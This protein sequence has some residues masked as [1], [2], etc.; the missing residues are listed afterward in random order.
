MQINQLSDNKYLTYSTFLICVA[1]SIILK[2]NVLEVG[3]PFVTIDD[4]STYEGGFLVWFGHPQPQRMYL[5]SWLN[6]F[7]SILTYVFHQLYHGGSLGVNLVVDAYNHYVSDPDLYVKSYRFFIII[8]DLITAFFVLLLSKR[9]LP[10]NIKYEN[11]PYLISA[12]YLLSFNTIW[13]FVVARPDT[14]VATFGVIGMY[15]YYRSSFGSNIRSFYLSA[16]FFGLAAGLKLH[17][18]FFVIFIILD[19]IRVHG[20]KK[21]IGLLLSFSLISFFMFLVSSGLLIFDPLLYIKLRYLN[22]LDDLSPWLN[23]GDQFLTIASG[24]GYLV[25]PLLIVGI[26]TFIRKQQFKIN[27]QLASIIFIAFMWLLLFSSLRQLRAYW[28]LPVLPLFYIIA[29]YALFNLKNKILSRGIYLAV[30]FILFYQ[31]YQQSKSFTEIPY[32][33]LR[34]WVENNVSSHEKFYI[35]GYDALFLPQSDESII[36]IK[37]GYK[38]LISDSKNK[39]DSYTERHVRF[40]E[41]RTKLELFD[42]YNQRPDISYTYYSYYKAPLDHFSNLI[43]FEEMDYILLLDDFVVEGINLDLILKDKYQFVQKAVGPGGG[44]SGLSYS[45]YKKKVN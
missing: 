42:M 27:P 19:L 14:L 37:N 26:I 8:T 13:C 15:L 21:N 4:N 11:A 43:G 35:F 40:W 5:E 31:S 3:A 10:I 29:V 32:N 36:N 6:G 22:Y 25:I 7:I 30:V 1:I 28:M 23:S 41:E 38:K 12:L 39:G 33:Q 18:A 9:V 17:G 20:L 16:I 44:G 34:H 45:I 24:T 2:L